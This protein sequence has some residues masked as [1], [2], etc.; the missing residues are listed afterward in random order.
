MIISILPYGL[1]HLRSPVPRRAQRKFHFG[2][3][4][5]GVIGIW[6][7]KQYSQS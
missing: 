3:A 6:Y 1:A 4:G 7:V 5:S 2:E